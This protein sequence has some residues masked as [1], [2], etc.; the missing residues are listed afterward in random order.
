M[1]DPIAISKFVVGAEE[2]RLVL[3]VLRSGRLAQGAMVERL[4]TD[5]AQLCGV[6]H[7]IAVNS[8]TSALVAA[9]WSATAMS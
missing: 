5:F 3:E 1:T 6:R 7:A 9:Y 8:G 4:E 2:E